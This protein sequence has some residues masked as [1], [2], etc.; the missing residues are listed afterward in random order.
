MR[1]VIRLL[2]F[3]L[4]AVV[5]AVAIGYGG[6]IAG[7][8][9]VSRQLM[10]SGNMFLMILVLEGIAFVISALIAKNWFFNSGANNREQSLIYLVFGDW[11][12]RGLR[13]P[14]I[15]TLFFP[16]ASDLAQHF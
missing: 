15:M 7:K 8:F 12:D 10:N 6:G 5:L 13:L 14:L 11:G 2:G 9:L 1:L 16:V 4:P 3:F